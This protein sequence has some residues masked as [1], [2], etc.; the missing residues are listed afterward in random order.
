MR[1]YTSNQFLRIIIVVNGVALTANLTFKYNYL[2][3]RSH[4]HH[5]LPPF[6]VH[7]INVTKNVYYYEAGYFL[8][9]VKDD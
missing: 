6:K 3:H 8:I 9:K 1:R 2:Q 4:S 5:S 7:F